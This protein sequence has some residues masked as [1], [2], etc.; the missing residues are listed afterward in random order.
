MEDV[1]LKQVVVWLNEHTG[2]PVVGSLPAGGLSLPA[3]CLTFRH[4]MGAR[5]TAPEVLAFIRE[6][7]LKRELGRLLLIE[8]GRCFVFLPADAD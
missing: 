2:R 4:P 8:R 6:A 1:T 3:G 5:L 7:L